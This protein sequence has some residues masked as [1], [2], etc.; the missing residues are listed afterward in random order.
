MSPPLSVQSLGAILPACSARPICSLPDSSGVG[1]KLRY[2]C[3]SESCSISDGCT[4]ELMFCAGE[5]TE[6]A[7]VRGATARPNLTA[8]E[9]RP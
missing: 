4:M 8:Q 3:R 6:S 5:A 9:T 7:C 1:A 2:P